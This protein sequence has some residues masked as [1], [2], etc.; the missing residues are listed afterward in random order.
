VEKDSYSEE[1]KSM[2][3]HH[4]R[5]AGNERYLLQPLD[6]VLCSCTH[7]YVYIYV[8]TYIHIYIYTYMRI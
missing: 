5:V 2:T 7:A 6:V 3:S 1:N 4:H 8:Y